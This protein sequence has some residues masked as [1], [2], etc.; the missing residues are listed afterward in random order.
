MR[1][2]IIQHL[3]HENAGNILNWLQLKNYQQRTL[4][5][6]DHLAPL[7]EQSDFDALIILGGIMSVH[8]EAEFLWLKTEK[9]F[10]KKSIAAGKPILGICL[11]SQL[12]AEALGSKVYQNPHQEIGIFPVQ[13]VNVELPLLQD[14]P[15][16]WEVFHWH[17]DTFDLPEGAVHL[18]RSLACVNQG[19]L[20]G[21]CMGLQ[22]HP[23]VD[24]NLAYSMVEFER[25]ELVKGQFVQ[26]EEELKQKT[27]KLNE[28]PFFRILDQLFG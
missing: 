21:K 2:L 14:V 6:P 26:T 23:E 7:P 25:E 13:K 27:G 12:L 9:R 24:Q 15:D 4:F 20:K 22:F 16:A 10:I 8:D 19:Y 5:M 11:G 28:K 1:F 17:G 3:T 18:F